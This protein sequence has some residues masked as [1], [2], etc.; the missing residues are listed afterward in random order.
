MTYMTYMTYYYMIFC[1]YAQYLW[2]TFSRV[3]IAILMH[4]HYGY[5]YHYCSSSL[6]TY[7]K[8]TYMQYSSVTQCVMCC[9]HFN[10]C[11]QTGHL[12]RHFPLKS[13][14][15]KRWGNGWRSG[16]VQQHWGGCWSGWLEIE[17]PSLYLNNWLWAKSLVASEPQWTSE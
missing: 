1:V 10:H 12:P 13:P 7:S 4:R 17:F 14:S 8:T 9:I 2:H 5:G 16:R 15:L 3:I 6:I 11:L